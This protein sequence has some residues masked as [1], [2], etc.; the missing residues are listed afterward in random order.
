MRMMGVRGEITGECLAVGPDGFTMGVDGE[1]FGA[2]V[3]YRGPE[4]EHVS[5]GTCVFVVGRV[6]FRHF[7]AKTRRVFVHAERVEVLEPPADGMPEGPT[8]LDAADV[9]EGVSPEPTDEGA[10]NP[11]PAAGNDT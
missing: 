8:Q 2:D 10:V 11:K 6:S 5:V 1:D 9:A 4:C 3:F 7:D